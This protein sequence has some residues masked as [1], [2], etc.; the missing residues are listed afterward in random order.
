LHATELAAL[1]H[2]FFYSGDPFGDNLI[3]IACQFAQGRYLIS[4]A[5][6]GGSEKSQSFNR[7]P[8]LSGKSTRPPYELII[9][10]P[11]TPTI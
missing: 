6:S 5:D 4:P 10:G 1:Q 11:L 3:S 9:A 8:A 7:S 2:E